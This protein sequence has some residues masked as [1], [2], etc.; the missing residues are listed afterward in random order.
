MFLRAFRPTAGGHESN[1]TCLSC[2]G[3]NREH[4]SIYDV[5]CVKVATLL[6]PTS[7]RGALLSTL[8]HAIV[9]VYKTICRMHWYRLQIK[10]DYKK[11]LQILSICTAL[12]AVEE[13]FVLTLR[14]FIH[15]I[16]VLK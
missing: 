5:Y 8:L 14:I 4:Q 16:V 1:F 9:Y 10:C 6:E 12:T 3:P 15:R 2:C 13:A 7:Y 11:L